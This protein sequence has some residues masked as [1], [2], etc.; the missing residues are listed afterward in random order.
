MRA[1]FPSHVDFGLVFKILFSLCIF[2]SLTLLPRNFFMNSS[3]TKREMF[4]AGLFQFSTFI[5]DIL[6]LDGCLRT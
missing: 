5:V 1:L 6:T 3:K 2:Y 4:G